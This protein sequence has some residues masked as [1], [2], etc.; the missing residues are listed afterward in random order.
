M[1]EHVQTSALEL[2]DLFTCPRF[3]PL[4][5]RACLRRQLERQESTKRGVEGPPVRAYCASGECETG[6]AIRSGLSHAPA[7][8]CPKCGSALIPGHLLGV[9]AGEPCPTC[10]AR[11]QE[12][13]GKRS[14][15]DAKHGVYSHQTRTM[16]GP[17]DRIWSGGLPDVPFVPPS[18]TNRPARGEASPAGSAPS[19]VTSHKPLTTT[20][21]IGELVARLDRDVNGVMPDGLSGGRQGST[22]RLMVPRLT[23]ATS[24]VMT[25][26]TCRCGCGRRLRKN[27][28]SGWSGY[29]NPARYASG[30]RPSRGKSAA[31]TPPA[32]PAEPEEN[33]MEKRPITM[34]PPCPECEAKG[35]RHKN[36]CS[37]PPRSAATEPAAEPTPTPA[38]VRVANP[39]PMPVLGV[40]LDDYSVEQLVSLRTCVDEELA[41]RL[42]RVHA[43]AKA[44]EEAVRG[45]SA[46]KERAA[47]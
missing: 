12:E 25:D 43:E 10:E 13:T 18:S 3:G 38:K 22:A 41:A 37:K 33:T 20:A 31:P 32:A 45:V 26:E 1:R 34:P 4:T 35:H 39:P 14:T 47:S 11:K 5:H 29:C 7:K 40:E 30:E 27:N 9:T 24:G 19:P 21:L 17:Q 15:P 8:A 44:L 36:G 28:T 16:T 46:E 42:D 2:N 23:P 6:R